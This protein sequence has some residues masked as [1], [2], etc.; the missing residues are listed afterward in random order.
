MW[1]TDFILNSSITYKMELENML[2]PKNQTFAYVIKE[3]DNDRLY[4][5]KTPKTAVT[6]NTIR[7]G[8]YLRPETNR[9]GP[10]LAPCFN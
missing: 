5:E 4:L 10:G 6:F 1:I 3:F 2:S 8:K 7:E 9:D